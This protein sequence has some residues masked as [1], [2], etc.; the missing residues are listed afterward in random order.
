MPDHFGRHGF[1]RPQSVVGSD[2]VMNLRMINENLDKWVAE[3]KV[4]KVKGKYVMDAKDFGVDKLLGAG[5]ITKP[6]KITVPKA[7]SKAI[8]KIEAAGGS[9]ELPE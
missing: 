2:E 3:G 1:K 4:K 6:L 5:S 9:V 7:S 8:E